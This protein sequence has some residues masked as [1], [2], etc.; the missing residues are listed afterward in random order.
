MVEGCTAVVG[1]TA[2]ASQG[3]AAL[4]TT[5]RDGAAVA[6][7]TGTGATATVAPAGGMGSGCVTV[8][9]A[10]MARP[11]T[12]TAATIEGAGDSAVGALLGCTA[13]VGTVGG[14]KRERDTHPSNSPAPTAGEASG[15]VKISAV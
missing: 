14:A 12:G 4:V 13:A 5:V 15:K 10:I 3:P 1:C 6:A 9:A 8:A 7:T 11:T 2:A